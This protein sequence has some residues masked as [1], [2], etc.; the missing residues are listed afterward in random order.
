[1]LIAGLFR[2]RPSYVLVSV[3]L[4]ALYPLYRLSLLATASPAQCHS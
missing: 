3:V 2:R 4:V 1:M